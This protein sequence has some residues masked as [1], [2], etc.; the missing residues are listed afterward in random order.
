MKQDDQYSPPKSGRG[1]GIDTPPKSH[2][3]GEVEDKIHTCLSS[4]GE[5]SGNYSG[6][7]LSRFEEFCGH[8]NKS[9]TNTEIGNLGITLIQMYATY[10]YDYPCLPTTVGKA[11]DSL[12]KLIKNIQTNI[13]NSPESSLMNTPHI[14][15][16]NNLTTMK[17]SLEI[18]YSRLKEDTEA[19]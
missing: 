13:S 9:K 7:F 6:P 8:H 16:I 14:M 19:I 11:L 3:F 12:N 18:I 1:P 15:L 2:F 10:Y 5:F 17:E 4:F